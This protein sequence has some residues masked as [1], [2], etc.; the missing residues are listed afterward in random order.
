MV[1]V[2]PEG[3]RVKSATQLD[4]TFL[5]SVP[6]SGESFTGAHVVARKRWVLQVMKLILSRKGFDSGAGGCASAITPD[7]TLLSL[8]IPDKLSPI[9]KRTL[10]C[11]GIDLVVSFRI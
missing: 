10:C 5:C 1:R 7:G 9:R 11:T 3:D 8:P 6:H 4:C 2:V